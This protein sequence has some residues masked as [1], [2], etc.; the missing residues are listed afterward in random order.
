MFGHTLISNAPT[1]PHEVA[2]G[3]AETTDEESVVGIAGGAWTEPDADP[4]VMVVGGV[5]GT[6]VPAPLDVDDE[7]VAEVSVAYWL[8][9]T[10]RSSVSEQ[11][12]VEIF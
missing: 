3:G 8:G 6:P 12:V 5:S 7:I 11:Q 10:R 2:A 1:W 9:V 4:I